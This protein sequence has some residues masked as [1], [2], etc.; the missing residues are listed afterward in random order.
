VRIKQFS[1]IISTLV[2]DRENSRAS[3]IRVFNELSQLALAELR[4]YYSRRKAASRRAST[5]RF[6]AWLLGVVGVAT[7]IAHPIFPNV[8]DKFL[9]WGYLAVALA[10]AFVVADKVFS[11]S[12][13]HAR[14]VAAQL[15]IEQVYSKFALEWQAL[16]LAYDSEPSPVSAAALLEKAIGYADTFHD[17]LGAETTEWRSTLKGVREE[18]ERQAQAKSAK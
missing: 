4:Y 13:A 5:F 7:P 14:F 12:E 9:N 17:S 6:F 16:L 10:G 8:S 11:G 18:L 1:E 3:L 15:R 2:W